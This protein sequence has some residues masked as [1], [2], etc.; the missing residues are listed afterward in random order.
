MKFFKV[1]LE[2]KLASLIIMAALFLGIIVSSLFFISNFREKSAIEGRINSELRMFNIFKDR[3]E[4]APTDSWIDHANEE[5]EKLK[6]LF[7]QIMKELDVPSARMPVEVKEPLKFKEEIFNVQDKIQQQA[8]LR[9]LTFDDQ[10]ESLGFREYET[11]IPVEAEVPNL[12]KKLLIAEELVELMF[13]SK[14]DKLTAIKF[15]DCKDNILKSE[16]PLSYRVFPI[17]LKVVSSVKELAYFLYLLADSKH[18][19]VVNS[20]NVNSLANEKN[21]VQAELDISSI[22]FLEEQTI[23]EE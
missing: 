3:Q 1:L 13:S 17:E 10:A 14:I 20:I 5:K 6:S 8:R 4:Y 7:S 11:K 21:Q 15:L 23:K 16:S 22:V 12:T 18:I 19:F 9:G 2:K